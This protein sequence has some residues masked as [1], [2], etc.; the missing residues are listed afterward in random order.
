M[1]TKLFSVALVAGLALAGTSF[2]GMQDQTQPV[3]KK[4]QPQLQALLDRA[5]RM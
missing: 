2:G 4:A 3:S 1:L 5:A